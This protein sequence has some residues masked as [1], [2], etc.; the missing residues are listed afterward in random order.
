MYVFDVDVRTLTSLSCPIHLFLIYVFRHLSC[1]NVVL[2]TLERFL[3]VCLPL[4]ARIICTRKV[5]C[6]V[7]VVT[8]IFLLLLNGHF[9]FFHTIIY[10]R[11]GSF[12]V[13][14]TAAYENFIFAIWY[15]ID[16]L[17]YV[18]L[19]FVIIAFCNC[20]ILYKANQSHVDRL[21]F[22]SRDR[23]NKTSA[24]LTTMTYMLVTISVAFVL[25]TL[26]FSLHFIASGQVK[27]PTEQQEADFTLSYAVTYL[28]SYVNNSINFLLYC[29]SG[30]QFRR[31]VFK[32]L[33]C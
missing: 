1:W 7:L 3:S 20:S 6:V 15:W 10:N 32:M 31:E 23:D 13:S 11:W 26:P 25:L 21:K 14:A 8:I 4:K 12:C 24:D 29:V 22:Q 19:P 18:G 5:T 2:L 16:L 27:N 28:I 30:T 17:C 33:K 9:L